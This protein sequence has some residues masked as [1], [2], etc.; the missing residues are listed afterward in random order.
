MTRLPRIAIICAILTLCTSTFYAQL[1]PDTRFA[2]AIRAQCPNCIDS[3]DRLKLQAQILDRLD[4]SSSGIKNLQ[5]LEGFKNLSDLDCSNNPLSI[6]PVLTQSSLRVLNCAHLKLKAVPLL[7]D[8]LTH[9]DISGNKI[10]YVFTLPPMLTE[11]IC[12]GTDLKKLPSL[13]IRL[14]V[15]D[16]SYNHWDSLPTLSN[17]IT[18]LDFSNNNIQYLPVLPA[19]LQSILGANNQ[20]DTLPKLTYLLEELIVNNNKLIKLPVLPDFL[21]VLNVQQNKLSALPGLPRRLASLNIAF[22]DIEQLIDLPASLRHL[23]CQKNLLTE[24][25]RLPR[26]L[27]YLNYQD[28]VITC[29]PNKP[30]RLILAGSSENL[31]CVKPHFGLVHNK[32]GGGDLAFTNESQLVPYR[33]GVKWGFSNVLGELIIPTQYQNATLFDKQEGINYSFSIVQ[34]NNKKGVIDVTG[35]FVVQP[36]FKDIYPLFKSGFIARAD[37]EADWVYVTEDANVEYQIPRHVQL[38]TVFKANVT[39]G[40][41][42]SGKV[43]IGEMPFTELYIPELTYDSTATGYKM[44][45]VLKIKTPSNKAPFFKIDTRDIIHA[46]YDS[47][48]FLQPM[49]FDTLLARKGDN[50][51]IITSKNGSVTDFLYQDIKTKLYSFKVDSF[52]TTTDTSKKRVTYFVAKMNDKWGALSNMDS[53]QILPFEY[54]D[55]DIHYLPPKKLVDSTDLKLFF[56]VR[57]DNKWGVM[58]AGMPDAIVPFEYDNIFVD[59]NNN[60]FLLI[61]D[62]TMGYF[63]ASTRKFIDTK[64]KNIKGFKNGFVEVVTKEGLT[65]FVNENGVEYYDK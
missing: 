8:S 50:W 61:K 2:K 51:G 31:V 23:D 30:E 15:F 35:D 39:N 57:K 13:P 21:K 45:Y 42:K 63:I 19:T 49:S 16:C 62:N 64:Y 52:I 6:F 60:G 40:K 58:A 18:H 56:K 11:F 59:A 65:G 47:I 46:H 53:T 41:F 22:N 54:D 25:P 33:K 4:I 43:F 36:I 26:S 29:L 38:D 28:N 14:R 12:I 44:G 9:L 48:K 20:L 17:E 10:P 37:E 34:L 27:N 1:I 24:L 5:G 7:P 32:G 3:L 55:I